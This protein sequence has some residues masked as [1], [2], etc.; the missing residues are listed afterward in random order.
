M[1]KPNIKIDKEKV[2]TAGYWTLLVG[3]TIFGALKSKIDI[4]K[5]VNDFTKKQ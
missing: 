2:I 3:S 5:A 4:G 1:N